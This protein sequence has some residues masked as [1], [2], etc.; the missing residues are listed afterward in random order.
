MLKEIHTPYIDAKAIEAT[1]IGE[2]SEELD[3]IVQRADSVI[4]GIDQAYSL[5]KRLEGVGQ[6]RD[7][8]LGEPS[9]R[10]LLIITYKDLYLGCGRDFYDYLAKD[11]L[12]EI[13]NRHGGKNWIPFENIYIVS[14]EDF[15]LFAQAI[16]SGYIGMAECL[17]RVVAADST[18]VFDQRKFTLRQHLYEIIGDLTPPAYLDDEFAEM[19]E[20]AR[21]RFR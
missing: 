15:D 13:S 3:H 7:I 21:S 5:A 10:F 4:K 20:R 6:I 16:H 19:I 2:V 14:I 12:D 18:S 1:Y 17:R 9:E 11:K 8:R